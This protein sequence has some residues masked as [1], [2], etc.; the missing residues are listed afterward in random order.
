MNLYDIELGHLAWLAVNRTYQNRSF[1]GMKILLSIGSVLSNHGLCNKRQR[2]ARN[3]QNSYKFIIM[4]DIVVAYSDRGI[5][6]YI[7]CIGTS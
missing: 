3:V 7:M 4:I 5:T 2:D 6:S 1:T